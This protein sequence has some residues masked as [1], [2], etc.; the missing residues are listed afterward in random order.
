MAKFRQPRS[1]S[2]IH[3]FIPYLP[4]FRSCRWGICFSIFCWRKKKHKG[5]NEFSHL[6]NAA[7]KAGKPWKHTG[8]NSL[9]YG[10][11]KCASGTAHAPHQEKNKTV[12]RSE[13]TGLAPR[14]LDLR[15]F[16]LNSKILKFLFVCL[17]LETLHRW[18]SDM[19]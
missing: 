15:I 9:Q 14:F 19:P 16:I 8:K 6:F 11:H 3:L 4:I 10:K 5:F 17:F 7:H 1:Y 13:R 2:L 18:S 12:R